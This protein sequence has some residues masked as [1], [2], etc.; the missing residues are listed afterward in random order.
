MF[1]SNEIH[2]R[3]VVIQQQLEM[4]GC[5]DFMWMGNEMGRRAGLYA[6]ALQLLESCTVWRRSGLGEGNW[7]K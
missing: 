5:K 3:D 1:S 2:K 6:A 7:M 4:R